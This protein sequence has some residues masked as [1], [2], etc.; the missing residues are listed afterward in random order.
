MALISYHA[1]SNQAENLKEKAPVLHVGKEKVVKAGRI[2][3]KS[4]LLG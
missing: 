3:G 2:L 4:D 1:H